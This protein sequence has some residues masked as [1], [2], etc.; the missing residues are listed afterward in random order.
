MLQVD[1]KRNK[2][3]F[4]TSWLCSFALLNV[5][6]IWNT[7]K[8]GASK[9]LVRGKASQLGLRNSWRGGNFRRDLFYKCLVSISWVGEMSC[10]EGQ[11]GTLLHSCNFITEGGKDLSKRLER[12]FVQELGWSVPCAILVWICLWCTRPCNVSLYLLPVADLACVSEVAFG[13]STAWGGIFT[14]GCW[15]LKTI[16]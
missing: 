12:V 6:I 1:L 5:R 2:S 14:G 3:H 4:R 11:S 10:L 16:L 13:C 15:L 8:S 7:S 9:V